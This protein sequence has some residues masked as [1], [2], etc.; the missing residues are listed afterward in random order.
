MTTAIDYRIGVPEYLREA[1]AGLYDDAFAGKFA[2]AI[3]DQEKRRRVLAEAFMLEY[4]V[5]ATVGETL[6]G[7]AGFHT[8]QGALTHGMTAGLLFD[9]LGVAAG[10]RAAVVFSLYARHPQASELLMDGI[11]V[12][13]GMR[14]KGVGTRLLDELKRF[15]GDNG[16]T[17]IRLDV[18]ETNPAARRLYERQGF[19][20]IRTERF[21]W[22]RGLLDFGAST[23]MVYALEPDRPAHLPPA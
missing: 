15:A 3:K 23:T 22:M 21:S 11:A 18:I 5:S 16:L 12:R 10:L 20:P 9:H 6:V 19:V 4:A 1:A 7:L 2:V 13:P 8:A 14:G 17:R